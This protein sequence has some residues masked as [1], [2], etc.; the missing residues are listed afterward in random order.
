MQ[1]E[2]ALEAYNSSFIGIAHVVV[3]AAGSKVLWP[4]CSPWMKRFMGDPFDEILKNHSKGLRR[5]F[6]TLW[7]DFCRLS[8][9]IKLYKLDA[10]DQLP[11]AKR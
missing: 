1:R 2:G 11:D 10:Y 7:A 9:H 3:E 5:R 4:R 8:L 6:H